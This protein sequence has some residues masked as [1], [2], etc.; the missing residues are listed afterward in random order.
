MKVKLLP[1]IKIIYVGDL[2]DKKETLRV[3]ASKVADKNIQQLIKKGGIIDNVPSKISR[4]TPSL[5]NYSLFM[6]QLGAKQSL[7]FLFSRGPP[8]FE[9]NRVLMQRCFPDATIEYLKS[10]AS[11][12]P[13]KTQTLI[14]S[15]TNH[16]KNDDFNIF[17]Y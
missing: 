2:N 5:G 1:Q 8:F 17:L 3:N 7:M 11:N 16:V 10:V 4:V 14:K 13:S 12:L 6:K 15:W 9:C